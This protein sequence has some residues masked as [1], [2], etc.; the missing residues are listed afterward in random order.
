M[1]SGVRHGADI[2]VALARGADMCMIGRAIPVRPGRRRPRRRAPRH[3]H[4]GG[5]VPPDLAA[6]G[7]GFGGRAAPARR[8]ARGREGTSRARSGRPR[9]ESWRRDEPSRRRPSAG[10]RLDASRPPRRA[11]ISG[12]TSG[13]GYACAEYLASR[14]DQVWV[15]GSSTDGVRRGPGGDRPGRRLGLRR[16]SRRAR[17]WRRW[18]PPATQ[19][20]GSTASSS[21]PAS[22]GRA[23]RRPSSTWSHFRRVTGCERDR[24]FPGGPRPRCGDRRHHRRSCSTLR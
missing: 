9:W 10:P 21:T 23:C 14:G 24:R 16:V 5:A 11:L 6:V 1:D 4:T 22:T 3:R 7:G 13:I 2:A 12:G 15:L 8:P 19:W 18:M 20:A 17:L